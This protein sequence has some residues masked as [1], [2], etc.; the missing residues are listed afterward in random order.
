MDKIIPEK[1]A[2]L[3][4]DMQKA[5][6]EPGAALCI[7]GA[8]STVPAII[9]FTDRAREAGA[10]IVWVT[11]SYESDGSNMEIP[12]RRDLEKR[13][14]MGVLAPGTTGINSIEDAEGLE[15]K[16]GDIRIVKPRFSAFFGTELLKIIKERGIDTVILTGT[17]TP[18][19]IRTTA[20]DGI[21]YDLRTIAAEDCC[22]SATDD[23]QKANMDDMKRIG[24]EIAGS[25]ELLDCFE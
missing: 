13:G 14:L 18:N 2:V 16:D 19:C 17:T 9:S 20:Y 23:I 5:F 8:K 4:I 15:P 25:K 11:R 6:V 3:V 12:R 7:A 21:S 1:T 22:S 10:S 24:V